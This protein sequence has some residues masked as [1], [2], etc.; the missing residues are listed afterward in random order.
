MA[1]EIQKNLEESS[2]T[3]K[4]VTALSFVLGSYLVF[5]ILQPMIFDN[6]FGANSRIAG[7]N[8]SWKTKDET[9]VLLKS[10]W[11]NYNSNNIVIYDQNVAVSSLVSNA[12]IEDSINEAM[13]REEFDYFFLSKYRFQDHALELNFNDAGISNV[14]SIIYDETS[15]APEDARITDLKNGIITPEKNGQR[16]M[17][18]ESH[19]MISNGL[20]LLSNKINIRT[21]LITPMLTKNDAEDLID[22]AR[23]VLDAP[24]TVT[25]IVNEQISTDKL[26][27]WLKITPISAKTL[28]EKETFLPQS[29]TGYYYLDQSEIYIYVNDL[30]KRIDKE[31]KNVTLDNVDGKL[32][33]VS[34]SVVG[35]QLD[36][37]KAMDDIENSV[38]STHQVSLNVTK[39]KPEVS[40]ADL[41]NLGIT[42]LLSEGWSDAIGSSVNRVH[43]YT[44]GLNKFNS[45]LIKPGEE[46][47]F[48]KIL[49]NVD[50][51]TGYLPE[52]V[53]KANK[54][55]PDYGGGLCQVSSTI[56]RA[57]LNAG[58]PILERHAH[59]YPVSYY[60]PYGVDATIYLPSP[61]FRFKN[62]TGH[63]ILIQTKTVGTK[64][65]FD[66]FGTKK[67]GKITFSGNAEA[68]NAVD[69]I[70]KVTSTIS[71]QGLRGKNSFTA[72]FYRHI[73]DAAGKL[74]DN[75]KFT[76][77]YDTP[78]NYPH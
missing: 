15:V 18:S 60:K 3:R 76:S 46:V 13:E 35:Q 75:D 62:D 63:Y 7:I 67:P 28:V 40:E 51:S 14:L 34:G 1:A 68:T 17:L 39:I 69:A 4:I 48:N 32:A 43:N 29:K 5:V 54:T 23:V 56:F 65:Y 10:K 47:S 74:T 77:K 24:I 38:T 12:K 2:P 27:K 52:L 59:A 16:L 66:F 57:A 19:E 22:S 26:Y 41:P 8:V 11:D 64:L 45:V 70:E 9:K 44:V 42:E 6:R 20:K 50:A 61:D 55:I 49:G 25:G 30:A 33:I 78:D 58:L 71:E 37:T 36:K 31:P 72:V 53:I 73:Y 21:Q